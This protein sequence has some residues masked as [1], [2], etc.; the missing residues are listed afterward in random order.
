ME[1]NKENSLIYKLRHSLAH[2]L[3]QAVQQEFDGVKLG[4]GPPVENGFYYDFDFGENVV[5]DTHLKQLEKK[6]KKII[7]QNQR[8][9]RVDTDFNGALKICDELGEPY[10]KE[11]IRNLF[12]K[13]ETEFS[14]YSNGPF[15]DICEGPHVAETKEIPK[16]CFKLDRVAGAYWL[17]SEKNKMLTRIYALCFEDRDGLENYLKRRKLAQENDHKKIGRELGLF[18]FD[19]RVGKG[20]PIWLPNGT[21]IRDEI[22]AFANELQKKAG[23]KKVKTPVLAKEDLYNISGHTAKYSDSMFPPISYKNDESGQTE[24]YY[25][26]PMCCPFH[27]MV[28][29]STKRSYRELPLRLSEYGDLFRFE[30]SGE[31]SG[32][33][34]VRSMCLNDAHLYMASSQVKDEIKAILAMYKEMYDTFKLKDYRFRLSTRG[35]DFDSDKFDG[36]DEMWEISEKILKQ[37]L[38]DQKIDY[39]IGEGEAAFYGP[40]IDIQFRNTMGREETVSTIQI[41]YLAAEKFDL[42]FTNAKGEDERPVVIHRAPLSTHE[43]F[44]SYI[45]EYYGGVFPTWCSPQQV[46]IIPVNETCIGYCQEFSEKLEQHNIRVEVDSSSDSF[47]KKIRKGTTQKIPILLIVG[48]EEMENST[49]SVR[50]FGSR[51]NTTVTQNEFLEA[52]LREIKQR[53]NHREPIGAIL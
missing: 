38:D 25:L 43:R 12:E 4:F 15:T 3:A 1:M 24:N 34:R 53:I 52:L 41:D 47:G 40:K 16:G 32:L 30:Q 9:E 19:E 49:V 39:Y 37:T 22:E 45:I 11:N 48:N 35:N 31:L 27:H 51:E 42:K 14:F 10:K 44:I 36:S 18:H 46:R 29:G 26:R 5:N 21:I 2:V 6:M 23:Y 8:F 28:Y 7:S 17:G 13:G 20:L 33:I 50:R